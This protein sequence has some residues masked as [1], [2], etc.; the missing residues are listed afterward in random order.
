VLGAV[1]RAAA[2]FS[3]GLHDE[4]VCP[5]DS[6][7]R[8]PTSVKSATR[9]PPARTSCSRLGPYN[10]TTDCLPGPVRPGHGGQITAQQVA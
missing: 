5:S 10:C 3:A 1:L 9:S 2:F 6:G 4:S 8:R 7:R